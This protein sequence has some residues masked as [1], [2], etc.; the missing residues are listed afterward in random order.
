MQKIFLF[1]ILAYSSL[2]FSQNNSN[3]TEKVTA[4]KTTEEIVLDGILNETVWQNKPV[5]GLTQR[6]PEEGKPETQKPKIW[7]AYNNKNL[8]VAA[9]LYDT[10]PE[11]IDRSLNR[12]DYLV[13]S[14]WF[15]LILDT[16][17]DD[18]NGYSFGV[19]AGGSIIDGTVFNDGWDD[20]SWDGIWESKVNIDKEG[21]SV[22][23]KIPFSQL[24]FNESDK[25]VWGINFGRNIKRNGE[26]S[27]YKMIPKNESGFIS[28]FPDL[29]GLDGIKPKQRIEA[30]PYIVQKVSYLI[31]NDKDPFYKSNQY[32][33][34]FGA[35][36]KIGVG[37]NFNID[38]TINPD[39]GQVEVDPAVVNLS[40]F[41]TF[42]Q[43][44]RPFFIEGQNLFYFGVG[45]ANNNWSFNFGNPELFYSRRIGRAPQ[46]T[47]SSYDF[48][49]RPKETR[50]LGAAK[51]TGKI[52][53]SWSL[54]AVSAATERTYTTLDNNGIR[55]EEEVEPF[56]H[57]GVLRSQKEFDNGT[58]SLGFMF[59]SVNRDLRTNTLKNSLN[60][61]AYTF[62]IDGWTFLDTGKVYVLTGYTVGSYVNGTKQQITNLQKSPYRY[63]QRP[64]ATYNILDTNKTSLTGTYSRITLNKQK[65]GFY[66]NA[67]LG[68]VTPG[69]ENNDLGFQWMADKISGHLVLGYRWFNPDSTFRRKLIY[70]AHSRNYDFEGNLTNNIYM[71]FGHFQFLNYYSIGIRS[72]YNTESIS[73][74]TTRGGPLVTTPAGLYIGGSVSSDSRKNLLFELSGSYGSD[75]LGGGRYSVSITTQWK[76]NT[77]LSLSIAPRYSNSLNKRQWIG[78]FEDVHATNTFGNRYVFSDLQQKSIS[79]SIRMSWS[80]TPTL[81]LQLYM[82]PLFAVGKYSNFKELTKPRAL[83]DK[84]YGENGSS[85]SYS[86]EDDTYKVDPDGNGPAEQFTFGNRDFNFKS[87]RGTIVLRWEVLPGSIFYLVWSQDRANYLD[88]GEL[89]FGRDFSNLLD[90]ES[91]NI[92]LAKFSYWLDF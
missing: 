6:E 53:D 20:Y 7:I 68:A 19:N 78:K 47:T 18:R 33:T 62:G 2:L 70:A 15:F 91:N 72:W 50:I 76:P 23:I 21:W 31:H 66:V 86:S 8:Y 36:F 49:D 12:R 55:T 61:Q 57:Y 10:N 59:T 60:K 71:F 69:F 79:A 32:Q 11:L 85:I 22:E 73:K 83:N 13:E 25:M 14:D 5:E 82:Q 52:D 77:Q 9:K 64:D 45:G 89:S 46:G 39:F 17:N 67:S 65:G 84:L 41:E 16:Y 92:F 4:Y 30:L 48:I 74:S 75:E 88:P 3:K 27:F 58:K 35:D 54:G 43:E 26:N 24:R 42:F 63:F 1:F 80:F 28:H 81:S 90:S 56:T 37:S 44:K 51:L 87:L 38:A 29:V 40:A 34:T